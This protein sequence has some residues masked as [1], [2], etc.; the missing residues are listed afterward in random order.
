MELKIASL[1]KT[2]RAEFQKLFN[3]TA[4]LL[5]TTI[6]KVVS[7]SCQRLNLEQSDIQQIDEIVDRWE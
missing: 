4:H 3:D 5:V 6:K 1:K 7:A 2:L